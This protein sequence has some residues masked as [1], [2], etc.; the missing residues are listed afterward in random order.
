MK[1]V[2]ESKWEISDN[3]RKLRK[4]FTLIELLVVIA[5]ISILTGMLLPALNRTKVLAKR[6]I[7]VS[8]FRQIGIAGYMYMQDNK[9]IWHYRHTWS[10]MPWGD[11]YPHWLRFLS[12]AVCGYNYIPHHSRVFACPE[13]KK[14]NWSRSYGI[15]RFIH[16]SYGTAKPPWPMR[17]RVRMAKIPSRLILYGDCYTGDYMWMYQ[18]PTRDNNPKFRHGGAWNVEMLDGH[19]ESWTEAGMFSRGAGGNG[20]PWWHPAAQ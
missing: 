3:M 19:V 20:T 12:D 14:A 5:I 18:Y 2:A 7:C 4:C 10:F 13:N 1:S 11:Y 15:N 17:S 9:D 8:N 16:D 6:A